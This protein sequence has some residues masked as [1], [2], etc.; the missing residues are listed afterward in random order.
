VK[1]LWYFDAFRCVVPHPGR[2]RASS[3]AR[4]S[5]S[6][7]SKSL[8]PSSRIITADAGPMTGCCIQKQAVYP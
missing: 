5:A 2:F 6:C 3:V 4:T 7:L 8:T 1:P